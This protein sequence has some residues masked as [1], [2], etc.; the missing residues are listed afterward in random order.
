MID[1][2]KF[3][4]HVRLSVFNGSLTKGQVDG[5]ERIIDYW[6]NKWPRMPADEM[7]YVLATIF[8]ETGRKMTPVKEGGGDRYLRSKKYY[9]YVGVGLIQV[10][11]AANWKRWDIKSVEDGLSWPIALR[12]AFEGMVTGAFTGKR[13]SDYIG[14]G[15]RDYVNARRIINGIDKAQLIAGY[16]ESFR[17]ALLEA[18]KE[19]PAPAPAPVPNELVISDD[20]FREWLLKALHE[21]EEVKEAII[22]VVFPDEPVEPDPNDE[23]HDDYGKEEVAYADDENPEEMAYNEEGEQLDLR[24]G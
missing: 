6:E 1:L 3:F 15:R 4:R 22:A 2:D 14:K 10:T 8:H 11:W 21:D 23:L 16:A 19:A 5:M 12:A 9:P 20:H 13:L 7:A 24:Y 18:T 17:T